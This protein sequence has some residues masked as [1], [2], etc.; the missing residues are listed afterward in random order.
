MCFFF[1]FF[2]SFPFVW[3]RLRWKMKRINC[4]C[5]MWQYI[6]NAYMYRLIAIGHVFLLQLSNS[7][8][9]KSNKKWLNYLSELLEYWTGFLFFLTFI[10]V[11]R[12]MPISC[13]QMRVEAGWMACRYSTGSASHI[14]KQLVYIHTQEQTHRNTTLNVYIHKNNV[15][16]VCVC[17]TLNKIPPTL[18]AALT[19]WLALFR[20]YVFIEPLPVHM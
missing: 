5:I 16:V 10:F 4:C 1:V 19:D 6:S 2:S 12:T 13:V 17:T 3:L 8:A 20:A 15:P 7:Q 11:E 14:E 18:W 9:P